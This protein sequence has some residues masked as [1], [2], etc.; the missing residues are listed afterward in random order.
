MKTVGED[1]VVAGSDYPFDLSV[2]PPQEISEKGAHSLLKI[3]AVSIR[4]SARL[5]YQNGEL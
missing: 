4:K 1:R 2:W 3:N 5:C